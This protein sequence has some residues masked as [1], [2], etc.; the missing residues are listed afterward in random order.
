MRGQPSPPPGPG[1][2]TY[3]LCPFCHEWSPL[4]AGQWALLLTGHSLYS[5]HN[6]IFDPS[7]LVTP[8]SHGSYLC[9]SYLDKPEKR[10][11]LLPASSALASNQPLLAQV[12]LLQHT[13][14]KQTLPM[15]T[16]T[17]C[18]LHHFFLLISNPLPLK[19]HT[20]SVET[21]THNYLSL[22]RI[23]V[24]FT[25]AKALEKRIPSK[26]NSCTT[27]VSQFDEFQTSKAKAQSLKS[28]N[29]EYHISGLCCPQLLLL[30]Q[31]TSI[32]HALIPSRFWFLTYH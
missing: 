4:W 12:A 18:T 11:F 16:L 7:T 8:D 26:D 6:A 3:Y 1:L 31:Y 30:K 25:M 19:G 15:Q 23:S 27:V 14:S 32:L 20:P 9:T 10:V 29:L 13:C 2:T 21:L 17:T 22:F 24:A 28:L 5:T